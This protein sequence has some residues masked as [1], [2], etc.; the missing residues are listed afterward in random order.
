MRYPMAWYAIALHMV[1]GIS[2]L[3]S[4]SPAKVSGLS[5][6]YSAFPNRYLL[7]GVLFTACGIAFVGLRYFHD[8]KTLFCLVPQQVLLLAAAYGVLLVIY[9]GHFADGTVRDRYFLITD[10]LGIVLIAV[11]HTFSLMRTQKDNQ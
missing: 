4:M 1:W 9:Q 6:L 11:F 10:K 8:I 5:I 3:F 7:A 2:L